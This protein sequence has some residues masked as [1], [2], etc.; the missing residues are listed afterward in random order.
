[1]TGANRV[2]KATPDGYQFVLG[3]V[4]THAVNQ[5]L[6]KRP[7]YNAGADFAPVALLV[8]QSLVLLARKDFPAEN[9][10]E[11]IV[12]A[13]AN[14]AKMQYSSSGTGGSNH[15]ACVLLNSAIG[16]D[17]THGGEHGDGLEPGAR[18]LRGIIAERELVGEEDRI[19][20]PGL[21][22]LRQVLVVADV[23]QWQRRGCRMP[24]RRLVMAPAVNEQIE[25]QL[26]L[27]GSH[28]APTA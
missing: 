17:V 24:P 14:Q 28:F 11:F 13:K 7:A 21:G 18:R 23:G 22:A 16:I 26:A 12:Y 2:A 20:Q 10:R 6:Y 3:N 15:L 1:M 25:M 9:L 4:G 8:D 27:H 19:E 5:S